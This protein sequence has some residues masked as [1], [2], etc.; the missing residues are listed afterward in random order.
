MS[1]RHFA[2]GDIHGANTALDTLLDALP[3]TPE[4]TIV[5]LGD[6]IDRGPGA[7]QVIERLLQLADETHLVYIM[8]NHEEMALQAIQSGRLGSFWMR[9]GGTEMLASYG[10]QISDI[11]QAHIDFLASG[12]DY[13]ETPTEVYVHANLDRNEALNE[14]PSHSLRW[15]HLTGWEVALDDGRRVICGHTSQKDGRPMMGDGWVCIDTCAHGGGKLTALDVDRD[16]VW[17]AD[18]TGNLTGPVSIYEI[19]KPLRH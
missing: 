13:Y 12:R 18:E 10:G 7:K 4:D 9:C 3:Y 2:I 1:G 14:Q 19:A 8:G 11:P 16:L 15:E 17:Q 6:I 5:I